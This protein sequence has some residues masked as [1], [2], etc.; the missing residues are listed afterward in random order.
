V[1]RVRQLLCITN[2]FL[3]FGLFLPQEYHAQRKRCHCQ[4]ACAAADNPANY[5]I[6]HMI[7]VMIRNSCQNY[8]ISGGLVVYHF[9]ITVCIGNIEITFFLF[10]AGF[11]KGSCLSDLRGVRAADIL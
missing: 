2:D 4:H 6:P 10:Q 9:L 11:F 5:H 7:D 8:I 1:K 3:L